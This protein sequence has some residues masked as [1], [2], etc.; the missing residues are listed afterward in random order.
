MEMGL[1][2]QPKCIRIKYVWEH[3][4]EENIK[5]RKRGSNSRPDIFSQQITS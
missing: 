1:I 3:G 2:S 4:Y 5:T